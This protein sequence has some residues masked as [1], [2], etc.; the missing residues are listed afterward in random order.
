[1]IDE[2]FKALGDGEW[3]K[4]KDLQQQFNPR[5]LELLIKLFYDFDFFELNEDAGEVR[6]CEALMTF[7]KNIED[8]ERQEN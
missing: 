2:V 3:H 7:Q 1:M 6:L 5:K 4:I 8:I